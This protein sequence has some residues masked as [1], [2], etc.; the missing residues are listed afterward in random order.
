M[1]SPFPHPSASVA[2]ALSRAHWLGLSLHRAL[3]FWF[4]SPGA[5]GVANVWTRSGHQVVIRLPGT[6]TLVAPQDPP[7]SLCPHPRD[8]LQSRAGKSGEAWQLGNP[9]REGPSSIIY[10]AVSTGDLAS[11]PDL[12]V[13]K[14]GWT[15]AT[16]CQTGVQTCRGRAW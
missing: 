11:D 14:R 3:S 15:G 16:S 13:R 10:S 2:T 12:S 4:L 8:T 6:Q 9:G 7:P 1:P 5:V